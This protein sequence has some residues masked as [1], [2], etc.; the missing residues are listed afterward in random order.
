M[1]ASYRIVFS[2]VLLL[3]TSCS[4][5]YDSFYNG[6]DKI[7][8]IYNDVFNNPA[9]KDKPRLSKQNTV[10]DLIKKNVFD[11]DAITAFTA[12]A[13]ANPDDKYSLFKQ[14]AEYSLKREWNCTLIKELN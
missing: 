14:S 10:H 13:S 11:V 5:Q 9:L 12:V 7:C 1:N 6:F 2:L 4:N 8:L 3:I